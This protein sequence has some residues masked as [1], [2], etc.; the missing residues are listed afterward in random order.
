MCDWD[1]F[2]IVI[3]VCSKQKA[4][5]LR[6]KIVKNRGGDHT[7]RILLVMQWVDFLLKLFKD[8]MFIR[9]EVVCFVPITKGETRRSLRWMR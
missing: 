8:R 9:K 6:N 7:E 2:G 3:A 1:S 4:A 5:Y